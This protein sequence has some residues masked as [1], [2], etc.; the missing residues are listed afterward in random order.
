VSAEELAHAAL[1]RAGELRDARVA[2]VLWRARLEVH[3]RE[4]AAWES[5]DGTV[6]AVDVRLVVDGRARRLVESPAV[7]D[8]LVEVIASV[9]PGVVSAS[10]V[11]LDVVWGLRERALEEGYRGAPRARTSREDADDVRA[12][13]VGYLA[14]GGDPGPGEARL[15]R[16]GRG[17]IV[18]HPDPAERAR[19]SLALEALLA[20]G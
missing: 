1:V 10:L 6:L 4:G 20:M 16:R 8:A 18:E 5:S 9:A 19:L 15:A 17:W 13:L 7:R 11:D 12:G 14:A 2:E 3:D